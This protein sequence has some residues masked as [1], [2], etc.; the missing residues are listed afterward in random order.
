M[1]RILAWAVLLLEFILLLAASYLWHWVLLRVLEWAERTLPESVASFLTGNILVE[2][3][4]LALADLLLAYLAWELLVLVPERICPSGRGARYIVLAVLSAAAGAYGFYCMNQGG[5]PV[6]LPFELEFDAVF[7]TSVGYFA[8][9]VMIVRGVLKM[10]PLKKKDAGKAICVFCYQ[11][12]PHEPPMPFAYVLG[13]PGLTNRQG[14]GEESPTRPGYRFDRELFMRMKEAVLDGAFSGSPL[15]ARPMVALAGMV[16]DDDSSA[17]CIDAV[18]I[19]YAAGSYRYAD[20]FA[21][22]SQKGRGLSFGMAELRRNVKRVDIDWSKRAPAKPAAAAVREQPMPRGREALAKAVGDF[23]GTEIFDAC[24]RLGV[25]MDNV[26]D[27]D[28]MDEKTL[29]AL[30]KDLQAHRR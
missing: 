26:F 27:I 5:I 9:A 7:A 28:R 17:N 2:D 18:Y 21:I 13:G 23:R 4:L 19:D 20:I 25:K 14:S 24:R 6:R 11:T 8:Y 22:P 12:S 30:L 3:G 29:A 10:W 1:K 15:L 16:S